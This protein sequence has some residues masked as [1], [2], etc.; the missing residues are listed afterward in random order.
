MTTKQRRLVR[1]CLI[2]LAL[3]ML[4]MAIS[5]FVQIH[6]N[7]WESVNAINTVPSGGMMVVLIIMLKRDDKEKAKETKKDE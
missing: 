2:I 4:T 3:S 7:G 6:H 1:I 5:T